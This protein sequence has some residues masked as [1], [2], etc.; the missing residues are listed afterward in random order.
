MPP[1]SPTPIIIQVI[2][3]VDL[4]LDGEGTRGINIVTITNIN[5]GDTIGQVIIKKDTSTAINEVIN[6]ITTTNITE[7]N[8]AKVTVDVKGEDKL[9]V[10]TGR[11]MGR[12]N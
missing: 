7:N 5:S 8:N 1:I 4:I 2:I 10:R 6:A 9:S 12:I 3:R 11:P